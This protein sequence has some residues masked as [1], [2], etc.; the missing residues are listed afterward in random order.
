MAQAHIVPIEIAGKD[1]TEAAVASVKRNFGDLKKL[2]DGMSGS[3]DSF[4]KNSSGGLSSLTGAMALLRNPA[5]ALVGTVGGLAAAG[6]EAYKVFDDYR[7]LPLKDA[8]ETHAR[9]LNLVRDAYSAAAGAAGKFLKESKAVIEF[10]TMASLDTMGKKLREQ[11]ESFNGAYRGYLFG[12][13]GQLETYVDKQFEPFIAAIDRLSARAADGTPAL[14]EFR[15][16]IAEI[17]KSNPALAG[18]AS[19][20]I[21]ASQGA[22]DLAV[23]VK[24]AAAMLRHLRGQASKDDL[25]LLGIPQPKLDPA[26]SSAY[27]TA[28]NSVTKH[29]MVMEAD[30]K[31]VGLAVGAHERLRVEAQLRAAI[32]RRGIALTE[33]EARAFGLLAERAEAAATALARARIANQIKFDRN[34][35]FLSETDRQIAQA[36]R[37]IYPDVATAIGSVEAAQMRLNASMRE[38]RDITAD[39]LKGFISDLRAGKTAAEAL[40][41]ALDRIATKMIDKS[42]DS[43]INAAFGSSS[44]L[45]GLFGSLFGS[46]DG[47]VF[48]A[49]NVIPFARGGVVTRP[50]L[51]PMA[52]GMGLMGEA[53]AEAVMPLARDSQGRLGVQSSGG[54]AVQ[55]VSNF[56]PTFINASPESEAR[57]RAEMRRELAMQEAR[58]KTT[59]AKT[60]LGYSL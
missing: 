42:I 18:T 19:E 15:G 30:A 43:L 33:D 48:A 25:D 22:A 44:G 54:R 37:E 14:D 32:E 59:I 47:N 1:S 28:I 11:L 35:M 46:A 4:A 41:N 8:M 24:E 56:S 6:Y 49:G 31:A 53:G 26:I 10:Q 58:L 36:L 55:V 57:M 45:G 2:I 17:G 40:G 50:T 51:F 5:V 9:S 52:N 23:K 20:L 29:V 60:S 7:N 34:T 27:Q 21:K 12:D 13:T 3:L 38:T 39:A 16:A